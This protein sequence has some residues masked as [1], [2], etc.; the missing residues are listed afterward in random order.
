[1]VRLKLATTDTWDEW[2]GANKR[3]MGQQAFAEFIEDHIPDIAD[4][5]GAQLL[6]MAT[7]LDA[8]KNATFSSSIRLQTGARQFSYVEDVSGTTQKGT[9]QI[10]ELFQLA[11]EPFAGAGKYQV[12]A[13]LRYSLESGHLLLHYHIIRSEDII[14]TA[15]ADVRATIAD[16]LK[17]DDIAM[18]AGTPPAKPSM[19]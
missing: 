14:R 9:V 1:M 10:P 15:F 5:P 16:G 12:P 7:T 17:S 6:E 13:R 11:L 4:P 3:K 2:M 8:K 19:P 18:L